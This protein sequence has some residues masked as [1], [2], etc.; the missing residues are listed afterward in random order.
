MSPQ[1]E[2]PGLIA[3]WLGI[4][5]YPAAWSWQRQ[6]FAARRADEI[7]DALMLL[8][9][10]PTYTKGRRTAPGDLVYSDDECR[11]RGIAVYDVDRGGRSTYH[12]PG[13]LVGYPIMALGGRY[14]VLSYLR[15][16][17]DALIRAVAEL[18][19]DARRDPDHTGVWVGANKLAAIGVK[20]T[21]GITMHG[22]ALNVTTDLSMF[23]GIVPCGIA[24]RWVTS[25][26]AET[27]AAHPLDTVATLCAGHLAD[28][29]DRSLR[30]TQPGLLRPRGTG[31]ELRDLVDVEVETV[32]SRQRN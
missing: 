17:E 19:V 8:E 5:E 1:G 15:G 18:G 2:R 26:Q 22:F 30:W 7:D 29:F 23:G 10:P 4:V 3:S 11:R 27:G 31:E 25:V 32:P 12:G 24:G 20:I 14:D 6:L 13:Q 21:R 28:G 9:H 16:L